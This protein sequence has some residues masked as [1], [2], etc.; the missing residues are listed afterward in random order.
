MNSLRNTHERTLANSSALGK[1]QG[2]TI[3]APA[4][5]GH[6]LAHQCTLG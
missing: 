3:T 1:S 2:S 5:A 6:R 4:C